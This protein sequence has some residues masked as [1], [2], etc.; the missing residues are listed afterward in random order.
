MKRLLALSV[1]TMVYLA[2]MQAEATD[3]FF[4]DIDS[5]SQSKR[6]RVTAK[7]PDN[8]KR[9]RRVA[10]QSGFVYV[11]TD[12]QTKTGPVDQKAGNGQT[13]SPG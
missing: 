6:Y 3:R 13:G 12:T 5:F 7:S 4:S 9:K 8:Q 1:L 11:C 10:F 2:S